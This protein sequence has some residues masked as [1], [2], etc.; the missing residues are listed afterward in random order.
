MA[1]A[2][3]PLEDFLSKHSVEFVPSDLPALKSHAARS[4]QVT[5]FYLAEL[6]FGQ[7]HETGHLGHGNQT[8]GSGS[9][10]EGLCLS[11]DESRRSAGKSFCRRGCARK[12]FD[13][14]SSRKLRA[15]HASAGLTGTL[16]LIGSLMLPSSAGVTNCSSFVGDFNDILVVLEVLTKAIQVRIRIPANAGTSGARQN[17]VQAPKYQE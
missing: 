7:R 13:R 14:G 1:G 6:A 5:D 12:R 15:D 9:H 11:R 17:L 3:A 8:F 4:D 16:V 2:R 10:L